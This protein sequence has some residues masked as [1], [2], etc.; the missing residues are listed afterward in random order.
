MTS[1][2]V[3]RR[4]ASLLTFLFSISAGVIAQ[5]KPITA[6]EVVSEIQK[7]VGVEWRTETVD[8]FKAGNPDT[9]ITGIAVTMM[10]TMDVLQ[11]ASEKGLN[12]VITHEPMFYAHLDVPEGMTESDPVW[13]EKRAFI[14]KHNLVVWRFHDHWHLRKPDGIQAGVTHD[15]GWEKYQNADNQFLFVHPDTTLKTLA[16]EVA[17]KLGSPIVRVVGDPDM[18]VTK[19]G[20]SLGAAGIQRHIPMLERD[21]VQVLLIGEVPEW[22]TIEYVADAVAQHRQKALVL[23]GHIPSEQPGMDEA[24]RWLKTF[25]SGVPI[26]FVPTKQPMWE[27]K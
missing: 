20:M 12:F 10:A 5:Q 25:V 15:L 18:T 24:T 1:H 19:V 3:V 14:E 17:K 13:A 4:T 9:P 11:R 16:E 22:E 7:H 27:V 2:G 23:I 8:T 26:E 6:R 21:D